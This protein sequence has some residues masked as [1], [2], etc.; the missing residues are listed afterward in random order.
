MSYL[1]CINPQA[2]KKTRRLIL[3]GASGS[4]GQT[5]LSYL[6][7]L[8]I[9]QKE[10]TEI[11]VVGI[12]VH[13]SIQFVRKYL[14]TLG[15]LKKNKATHPF[16]VAISNPKYQS[17][18][19][20]LQKEFSHVTFYVGANGLLDMIASAQNDGADTLLTAI[21]GSAGIQ[22][23][24]QGIYLGM[25]IALANKETLVTAGPVIQKAMLESSAQ[26]PIEKQASL[27]PT[28]SEHNSVFRMLYGLQ[29][30][31]LRRI[32]LSA[33]GGPFRDLK[34]EE[35]PSVT[36]ERVLKHPNWSMGN[37]ITVDSASM[38][39]KG[40]EMIEAHYVFSCPYER[41]EAWL[42]RPSLV[43]AIAELSDGS[44]LFHA[45]SPDMVFPI[46]HVLFFPQS[47]P[48][49]HIKA[50]VSLEWE[51]LSFSKLQ[52]ELYP[53]FFL[54]LDAGKK[55]G[56]APAILNAANEIAVKAFLQD[57]IHFTQIVNVI[58]SIMDNADIQETDDLNTF[59]EADQWARNQ[60]HT[61]IAKKFC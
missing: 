20:K 38:I 31:D 23:T 27:L 3:L 57:K 59:L 46:A 56:T 43:H 50:K 36:K 35:L 21:V 24:L 13:S 54:C 7:S 17:E 2:A 25:K 30:N 44:Y 6:E 42:H 10:E 12:S 34:P 55:G 22:A 60:A 39:N 58:S 9:F 16:H 28:D 29:K 33:S 8:T 26:K 1:S 47:V 11:E 4:I 18:V 49:K 48:Q 15:T 37:K 45:S 51:A 40:L 52:K 61:L 41:L 32:I 14:Y 19:R 5:T 53:G